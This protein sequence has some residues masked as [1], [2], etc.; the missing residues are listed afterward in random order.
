MS[1]PDARPERPE[2]GNVEAVKRRWETIA[3]FSPGVARLRHLPQLLGAARVVLRPRDDDARRIDAV[4]GWGEKPNTVAAVD[5]ARRH[6]LPYW[7]AEDGFLRSIRLGVEGDPPLS[8][9]LDDRGIYYD[10][11]RE[12]RLEALIGEAGDD[13]AV[14]ARARRAID[15]IVAARLSKYNG[16]PPVAIDLGAPRPRVLVVDQ[17]RGDLSVACGLATDASFRAMLDAA[18]AENPDAEVLVKTH[19][20]VLAGKKRGYLEEVTGPRIRLFAQPASPIELATQVDRVYVVTSQVGLEALLAGKPVTCFG[21]P[22]YAGWGLTDDRATIPRRGQPRSLEQLFAAAYLRYAR[23]VDPDTGAPCQ[24]ERILDHLELQ[25][26]MFERN[27][28]TIFCFGFRFWKRNYVRAYLRSPG[29]RIVFARN[30]AQAERRGFDRRARVVVWGQRETADVRALAARLGVPVWRMEDGFLR[31]VGLGSDLATPAS[32]VV[33]REGIY[34]DPTRRSELETILQ[35]ASVAPEVLARAA[36]L[37]RR[38]VDGRLSKYNVGKDTRLSV[39]TGKRVILVPGQVE[40][41]ASVRL[42]GRDITSNLGLL[43]AVRAANPDAFVVYKPHPD[44]ISGNRAGRLART[45]AL[46]VCDHLEE[47][48]SLAQCLDVADEVHTLTSLV[49]FEGLLRGRRVVVYGQPFYSGWGLTEDKHPHPR[50]TRRLTLDEL[51][52]GALILYPRYLNRRSGHFTTPE[53][54]IAELTAERDASAGVDA[55]R[56]SWPRRQLRKL[57]HAYRGVV[58]AP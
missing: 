26:T 49:G 8:I 20:D 33:D 52:A 19:P 57:R 22:F 45:A 6:Q 17:T 51:V 53:A 43:R 35:G 11:R 21:A 7:R 10:A 25:R 1:S 46:E 36:A 34:Y 18:L 38:I 50:R 31:S 58:H 13:P 37:R 47:E 54:V 55:L 12:S 41:D 30:A 48:A 23:Y 28:G 44:V 39:P 14:L 16:A 29:N 40:D 42:G 15:R 3:T 5:Y 27:Q 4:I 56:V 32:L 24:L 2:Q 9:V